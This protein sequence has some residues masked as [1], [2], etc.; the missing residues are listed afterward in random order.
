MRAWQQPATV[1]V[2][3]PFWTGTARRADIVFPATTPLERED[4]GGSPREDFL[5][6]MDQVIDPVG[7]ARND[8]DIFAGLAERLGAGHEFTEG[9]TADQWVRHLYETYRNQFPDSPRY[10]EF[11]NGGFVQHPESAASRMVLYDAF[12][13]DPGS[14]PLPTPSGK[15]ELYSETLAGFGYADCPP[16]PTFFEPHE[17]LGNADRYQL[18]MI[19]NQPSTRLHSQLDH[20]VTST[21]RK[22]DGREA[23]RMHPTDAADRGI[24]SGDTVRIF[25]DRGACFAGVEVTDRLRRGVVELPTGAWWDPVDPADPAS[26]CRHGNPNVLTRDAGTSA[27]AQ[28]PVAQSCLVQIER[29]D[30]APTPDPYSAPQIVTSG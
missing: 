30:N 7:E 4:I 10:D 29:A 15:V 3:E 1:V 22:I 21:D 16:H 27:L 2:N 17:W 11:V 5:F 25:N 24:R 28:G 8:Y 19:S 12:R 9:R 14:Y 6:A 13:N 20:G 26:P 23:V 18:H